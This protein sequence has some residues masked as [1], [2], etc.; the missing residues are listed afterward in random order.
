[1]I[2]RFFVAAICVFSTTLA[3]SALGAQND[4]V[5]RKPRPTGVRVGLLG[6]FGQPHLGGDA[7]TYLEQYGDF[8]WRP[9]G[10]LELGLDFDQFAL[11]AALDLGRTYFVEG[12]ASDIAAISLTADWMPTRLAFSGWQPLFSIGAIH[13]EI[14]ME[15]VDTGN[16]NFDFP[17]VSGNGARLGIALEHRLGD[18][19]AILG[20]TSIDVLSVN[21]Q[22]RFGT[23]VIDRDGWGLYPRFALGLRWWPFSHRTQ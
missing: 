17:L 16:R 12:Q 11:S 13:E 21:Q 8:D 19:T 20:R 15:G 9:G 4:A 22:S 7:Q 18:K 14:D 1:M 23:Y 6:W 3:S 10:S 5:P 2:G